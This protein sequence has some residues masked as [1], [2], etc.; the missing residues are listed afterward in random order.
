MN[1]LLKSFYVAAASFSL[2]FGLCYYQFN[3][4]PPEKRT[5]IYLL[6]EKNFL[7]SLT[8]Y[9]VEHKNL[10]Q[11]GIKKG[12]CRTGV[13]TTGRKKIEIHNDLDRSERLKT[14]PHELIHACFD[15]AGLNELN[16]ES[17][18]DDV[19]RKAEKI[20]NELYR[21]GGN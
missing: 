9:T 2:G 13:T 11:N 5:E 4:S 16:L 8:D 1:S 21:N 10:P 19:E 17:N 7:D 15:Q 20:Y 18:D 3:Y 12:F 6:S 14:V